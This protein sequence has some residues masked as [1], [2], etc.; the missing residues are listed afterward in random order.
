MPRISSSCALSAG[1]DAL[2]LIQVVASVDELDLGTGGLS[3]DWINC[4]FLSHLGSPYLGIPV[5]A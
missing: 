2:A 1:V 3:K 5:I 4:G